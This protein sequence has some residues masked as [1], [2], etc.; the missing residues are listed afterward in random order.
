[1]V[2]A[3]G[4]DKPVAIKEITKKED[5]PQDYVEQILMRLR[6]KGIIKSIRGAQGGYLL[7][8][9]PSQISVK[10]VLEALEGD[11]FEIVC[12][13]KSGLENFCTHDYHC[14]IKALWVDLKKNI[15]KVLSKAKLSMFLD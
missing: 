13:R 9:K 14:R 10:D 6:R 7:A 1:V 8:Q 3:C 15:D 12:E 11:T 4:N 2:I 5:L